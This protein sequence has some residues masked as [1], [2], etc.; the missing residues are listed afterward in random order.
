[1]G[2]ICSWRRAD[3]SVFAGGSRRLRREV[4]VNYAHGPRASIGAVIMRK[5]LIA[6]PLL[7][8]AESPDCILSHE[9]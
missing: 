6:A 9:E 8:H 2:W 4:R 5:H 1:V 3:D 7:R